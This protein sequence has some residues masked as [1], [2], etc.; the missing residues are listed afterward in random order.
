[1]TR[2]DSQSLRRSIEVEYWV[3]D[4]EGRLVEPGGLVDATDGAEREFVEPLLEI[5]TTPCETAAQLRS[6]LFDRLGSVLRRAGELDRGLVPLSTPLSAA[7]IADIPDDRTRIQDRAIGENFEYVRHCAGTHVHVE[8]VPGREIDQFN[9]LTALDPALALV[10]SSPYFRGK[11][12]S[13][14]ARSQLYRW[15]AYDGLSHQGDLPP[16][17]ADRTQWEQRLERGHAS[18]VRAAREAGIDDDRIAS[19]FDHED[20][21]WIP[22]KLRSE[23]STVEWRSPD[24]ALPSQVVQLADDVVRVVERVVE[25]GV[26]VGG[27]PGRVTADGVV[28][29]EFETVRSCTTDAIRHGLSSRRLVTYLERLGFDVAAYEPLTR[30]LLGRGTLSAE[31]ARQLRLT[32]ADRL[33]ADVLETDSIRAD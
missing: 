28:L 16:Y 3:I 10:N 19:T 23:F 26:R 22:V 24:T 17:V 32:Y 30:Q 2:Q 33:E 20:A 15:M 7:D 1:M 25:D 29:P 13:P 21:V 31:E 11:Q 14:G 9:T 5:K 4:D 18:F 27:E 8:Q 6:E 12:L